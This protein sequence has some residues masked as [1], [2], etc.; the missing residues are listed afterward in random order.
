MRQLLPASD[1]VDPLTAYL[2]ADRPAG[3]DRPW[4]VVGMISSLDGGTATDGR[5]GALGG[6]ADQAVLRAVRGIADAVMVG[7]GTVVAEDYGPLRHG[8]EV[9]AARRNAGRRDEPPRLV[10]VSGRLNLDASSRVFS[11]APVAPL[12]CTTTRA[13]PARVAALD[14]VAEI[15]VA[16]DQHVDLDIVLRRL[17]DDGADVVVAE[18]GPTLN[19]ALVERGLVD[20]WCCTIAPVVVG[21]DSQRIVAGAPD[22]MAEHELRSL[23]SEDALLFGRW[24]RADQ[25]DSTG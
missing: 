3:P 2:A 10:I 20:E 19:G 12:V 18:G 24:V 16:G 11:D 8:D 14:E 1:D 6:P 22:V 5:S 25:A 13:D 7:A 4:V 9:R 23:L 15:L 21:G 17:R